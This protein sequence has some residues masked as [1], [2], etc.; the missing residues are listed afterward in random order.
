MSA[1]CQVSRAQDLDGDVHV[2]V[3]DVHGRKYHIVQNE[4]GNVTVQ[5]RSGGMI[6]KFEDLPQ[7]IQ[8]L[9]TAGVPVAPCN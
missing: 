2:N 5:C 3:T 1:I 6:V 8:A 4:F 9:I 7:E